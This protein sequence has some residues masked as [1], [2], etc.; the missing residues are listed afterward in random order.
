MAQLNLSLQPRQSLVF[1]SEANEMLYGGAAGGGKSYL[2]RVA[3]IIWALQIPGLQV[4]LF[5]R[6]FPDLEKNH[7]Q[8]ATSFPMLL[9]EAID[10]GMV[11]WNRSKYYFEFSNGSRITLCHCA[12]DEDRY[13]YLG[14]EI[15]VLLIDELSQFTPV[16]YNFLRTR[17]RMVGVK[18]PEGVKGSFPKILAGSNPGGPFH[19]TM[20]AMWVDPAPAMEYHRAPR[21]EGGMLRQFIPARIADNEALLREDPTYAE[22]LM[23]LG[24][25]Q[26]VKAYLEGDFSVVVGGMFDDVWDPKVHVL[27]P[28]TIP[29][30][31]YIDRA[32][33]WGST[34]PFSVGFWAE[35]DGTPAI[36]PDGS[37]RHFAAG[38]LI[39]F[40]EW[41]GWTGKPDEGIHMTAR[42]IAHG[43]VDI[44]QT[45]GRKVYPGPADSMIWASQND[46]CIADDMSDV[47]IEWQKV[48]KGAGSR[49]L[50]WERIRGLLQ[51]SK[52]FPP[53][54]PGLFFFENC[55]NS[56]RVLPTA[57]R[58]HVKFDDV[59]KG[60][61]DH[62]LDMISYRVRN[63]SNR[64]GLITRLPF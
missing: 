50:G 61:E 47:G 52:Q 57:P 11:K 9:A 45:I 63:A 55:R 46:N 12:K 1:Q 48:D 28:F 38:S 17:V 4:Y 5:R 27:K 22:R 39:Q 20:K 29:K 64:A 59:A 33:D 31:W 35:S 37:L 42:E 26:L 23:G 40:G 30:S 25:P 56:I 43:I 34:K 21:D 44:E 8:G 51:A 54:S 3:A 7:L 10:Q 6:Q 49:H 41:Y 2:M 19:Q 60:Y 16:V 53:E 32:F 18:I 24:D 36:L 14:A 62:C 58:C 13:N 15:H